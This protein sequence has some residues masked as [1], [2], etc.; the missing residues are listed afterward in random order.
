MESG[1]PPLWP[2]DFPS[3][4]GAARRLEI[5]S[6]SLVKTSENAARPGSNKSTTAR[7]AVPVASLN[8][9]NRFMECDPKVRLGSSVCDRYRSR[10]ASSAT[11]WTG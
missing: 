4:E 9:V 8:L 2:T 6:S 10:A 3:D 5:N 11:F 1:S 7:Q